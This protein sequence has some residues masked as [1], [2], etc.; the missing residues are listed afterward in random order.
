[1]VVA[2]CVPP[3]YIYIKPSIVNTNPYQLWDFNCGITLVFI[4][5]FFIFR[6]HSAAV[7]LPLTN[8]PTYTHFTVFAQH[9][10]KCFFPC[11]LLLL[12]LV[13]LFGLF[14]F[15][16]KPAQTVSRDALL[17]LQYAGWSFEGAV[18]DH[19][20]AGTSAHT[21]ARYVTHFFSLHW[22]DWFEAQIHGGKSSKNQ[23]KYSCF[24]SISAKG[25]SFKW[26]FITKQQLVK[27]IL[28]NHILF[29]SRRNVD[30]IPFSLLKSTQLPL[31]SNDTG[32]EIRKCDSVIMRA[33]IFCYDIKSWLGTRWVSKFCLWQSFANIK[34]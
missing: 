6:L 12:P 33:R 9:D 18:L 11:S 2:C 22:C 1:M 17:P 27:L 32:H 34:H 7:S 23:S 8:S 13:G 10:R 28:K 4:F 29:R 26:L 14:T 30:P 25:I 31:N 16:D 15:L 3:T 5:C 21:F 24:I 19:Q 20:R